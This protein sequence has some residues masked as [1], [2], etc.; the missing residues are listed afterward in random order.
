[1]NQYIHAVPSSMSSTSDLSSSFLA[2]IEKERIKNDINLSS[3]RYPFYSKSGCMEQ[4][5][6]MQ[7]SSYAA[8]GIKIKDYEKAAVL[9]LFMRYII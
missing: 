5:T 4:W 1:M 8:C 2:E 7:L 3:Y 6:R 9:R